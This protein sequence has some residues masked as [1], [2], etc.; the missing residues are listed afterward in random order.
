M[1]NDILLT[2]YAHFLIDP[3]LYQESR[4][5]GIIIHYWE[6]GRFLYTSKPYS[7]R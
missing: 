3:F 1:P 2:K 6:A 4:E 7:G 5:L